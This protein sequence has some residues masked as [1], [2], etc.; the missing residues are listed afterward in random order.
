MYQQREQLLEKYE[1]TV[2]EVS[3]G[4]GTVIADTDQGRVVLQEYH[5]S[6]ERV[7]ALAQA[8]AYLRDWDGRTEQ[9]LADREGNYLVTDEEGHRYLLKTG[10]F[11]R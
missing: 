10:V 3:K 8:L 7:G 6:G 5:G 2:K 11:G 4:R 1:L 9:L